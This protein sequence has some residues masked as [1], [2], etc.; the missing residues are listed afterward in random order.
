MTSKT[1]LIAAMAVALA[2]AHTAQAQNAD[3]FT[4]S[5]F[6]TLG[7]VHSTEDQADFRGDFQIDRGAGASQRTSMKPDSR[8]G[9][10]LDARFT[11]DFSGVVQVV[12]EHAI[13]GS[14][15]PEVSLAHV[16][17]RVSPDLTARLG[18]IT[19]PL[20]ML[21]EYQRVGYATPWVR[22]P[23]EVYNYLLPL[24][25][26]EAVYSISAGDAVIGV[27]G[28]YGQIDSER[29]R[30]DGLRGIALQMDAGS[31]VARVSH[32]RGRVG[33]STPSVEQLFDTY[34]SLPVPGLAAMAE[35][36]DPRKVDGSFTGVGYSFDPGSWFLRTEAIQADYTPS[37]SARTRSGYVSAGL[38]RGAVTPS[39]TFAHVDTDGLEAPGAADPF[40]L[41]NMAV[42]ANNA[43]RHSITA[44][45]RWDVRDRIALKLQGSH[46]DNHAGSFGSLGNVQPG[47][48]TGRSYRLVSASVDFVF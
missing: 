25:G 16:R 40:G 47:F 28:F 42:A 38:R 36:L 33:Y 21:S 23:Y 24:D 19:A 5:G 1:R 41:L 22:P 7:V 20:Y 6:G 15:T 2:S 12:S 35:R 45:V 13:T 4:L 46:V 48:E 8:V 29:V 44:A 9:V 26:I 39:L 11:D 18:R 3:R 34:R 17:Y 14:Y 10:Q 27:Q 37:L 31:H 30:V 43:S 32:I